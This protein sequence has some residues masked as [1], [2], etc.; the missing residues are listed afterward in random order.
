MSCKVAS[1]TDSKTIIERSGAERLLDKGDMLYHPVG[2][3]KPVRVQSAFVSDSEVY[4]VMDALREN[5][6]IVSYDDK[7]IEDIARA[8]Q[9]CV[10]S[11][12]GAP[13]DEHED[14][15]GGNTDISVYMR[16]KQFLAAVDIAVSSGKVSTS[17]I[18]R[19]IGVGYSKAAKFIDVM[20]EMH[21]VSEPNGQKP[22]ET[23]ITKEDWQEK[24]ASY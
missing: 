8:A 9:K 24:L 6:D 14:G 3:P 5:K 7:V 20:E 12:G 19:R 23:L 17:L 10:K 15:D 13:M 21:I 1:Y 11:K 16:D 4:A 2:T 22:R 18:Q